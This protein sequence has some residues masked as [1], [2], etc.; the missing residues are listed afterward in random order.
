M[1]A[2]GLAFQW[3][4]DFRKRLKK[5]LVVSTGVYPLMVSDFSV[6]FLP[7]FRSLVLVLF[8]RAMAFAASRIIEKGA[9]LPFLLLPGLIGGAA[10]MIGSPLLAML[11][12]GSA[13]GFV[14][15]Q[16]Q[17]DLLPTVLII[18]ATGIAVAAGWAMTD[19]LILLGI[20]ITS[21]IWRFFA[22]LFLGCSVAFGILVT[23]LASSTD[24]LENQID[25]MEKNLQGDLLVFLNRARQVYRSIKTAT[26]EHPKGLENYL[27]NINNDIESLIGNILRLIEKT[28]WIDIHFSPMELK[29]LEKRISDLKV[30]MESAEDDTVRE[31]L[32]REMELLSEQKQKIDRIVLNRKRVVSKLGHYFALLEGLRMTILTYSTTDT[33][34]IATE[35]DPLLEMVDSMSKEID[36]FTEEY[37]HL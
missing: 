15:A 9:F 5:L 26:K 20:P 10:L 35:M 14:I 6:S 37:N 25:A 12:F 3:P 11:L 22:G 32:E 29:R 4:K 27:G 13:M 19:A 31:N 18:L 30:K 34:T 33:Q 24:D 23:G 8:G 2:I 21:L 36:Y 1:S 7:L 17:Q 28:R 16:E